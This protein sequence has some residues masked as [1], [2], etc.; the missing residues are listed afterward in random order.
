MNGK[1]ESGQQAED[2]TSI[3]KVLDIETVEESL[4]VFVI[5]PIQDRENNVQDKAKPKGKK[6]VRRKV[7]KKATKE[8][9]EKVEL[10]TYK[11]QLVDVMMLEGTPDDLGGLGKK[12]PKPIYEGG[13]IE[14]TRGDVGSPALP[15]TIK[16]LS[17]NCRGLGSPCAAQALLRLI[18]LENPTMIF[19][20]ETRLKDKE[21]HVIKFKTCFNNY[22]VVYCVGSGR[23]RAAGLTLLWND[24]L[25]VSINPFL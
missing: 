5:T 3:S 18:R 6:W 10:E 19:L 9:M 17:W 1:G 25:Q 14:E 24:N 20:M 11:R 2:R 4:G 16:L 22:V 13:N 23:D 15:T 7:G 8:R 12:T 21:V